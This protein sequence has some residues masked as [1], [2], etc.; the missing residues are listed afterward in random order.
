MT[1]T[2][3]TLE[4][5]AREI[6]ARWPDLPNGPTHNAQLAIRRVLHACWSESMHAVRMWTLA[7]TLTQSAIPRQDF[8]RALADAHR[9]GI[10]Q[11]VY[12]DAADEFRWKIAL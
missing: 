2:I 3:S 1:T 11:H 4:L 9:A 10:V 7:C 5:R 12:D 8:N 6:I